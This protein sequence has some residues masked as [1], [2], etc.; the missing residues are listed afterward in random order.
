MVKVMLYKLWLVCLF[1]LCVCFDDLPV[2][3]NHSC[4]AN[5]ISVCKNS[6]S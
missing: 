1:H 3:N 6:I 2:T 5:V 4:K